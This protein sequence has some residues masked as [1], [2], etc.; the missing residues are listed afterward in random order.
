MT[1][2]EAG[3][4]NNNPEAE[5]SKEGRNETTLRTFG[6]E[7]LK[8]LALRSSEPNVDWAAE[9]GA[10]ESPTTPDADTSTSTTE[11][12]PTTTTTPLESTATTPTPEN[13]D[14][15]TETITTTTRAYEDSDDL[16]HTV[17]STP[18]DSSSGSRTVTTSEDLSKPPVFEQSDDDN[19]DAGTIFGH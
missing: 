19:I 11:Y 14:G 10:N 15:I 5:G 13:G 2:H 4:L 7:A 1:N 12:V 18:E 8:S 17:E 3:G 6:Q 16:P 9:P